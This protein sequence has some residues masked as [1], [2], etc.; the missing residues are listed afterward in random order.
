MEPYVRDTLG[1]VLFQEQVMTIVKEVGKFGWASTSA[2]R[3]AMSK[4]LG[5]EHFNKYK[6]DFIEGAAKDG[7]NEQRAEIIWKQCYTHGS[8]SFN[9]SHAVSYSYLSYWTGWMKA[10]HPAQFYARIL[11]DLIDEAEIKPVLKEW[12]GPFTPLDLNLSKQF[13]T[14]DGERLIGGFTNIKGVGEKAADKVVAG[15]PY[16]GLEDFRSRMPNGLAS[17][18]E[19]ALTNGLDWANTETLAERHKDEISKMAL[20][21]PLTLMGE[22]IQKKLPYGIVLGKVL[23]INLRNSNDPD[24]VAK[25]GRPIS[26]YPE[27][28]ILKMKDDN[29]DIWHVYCPHKLTQRSKQE[30]L[31]LNNKV[32]LF[33]LKRS[34]DINECEKFKVLG[35]EK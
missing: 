2:V 5:E 35:G 11:K 4:S 18:V 30:L 17:K 3:V 33:K 27:Y 9:K 26:G 15:Q 10:H 14:T 12:G 34:G 1:L 13:F 28:V 24:K 22:V 29:E 21:A 8:W 20:T 6:K 32:C 16:E 23:G 25:R 7:I 19:D 31:S